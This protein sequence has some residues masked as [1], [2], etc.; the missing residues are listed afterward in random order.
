MGGILQVSTLKLSPKQDQFLGLGR[1]L[2]PPEFIYVSSYVIAL[3]AGHILFIN[4]V[5]L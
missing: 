4:A 1:M 2:P 5:C 3:R